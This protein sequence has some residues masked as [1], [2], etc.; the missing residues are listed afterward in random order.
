MEDR[1]FRLLYSSNLIR[2]TNK[3]YFIGPRILVTDRDN[4]YKSYI[5]IRVLLITCY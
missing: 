5:I 2:Q 1:R 3:T 4:E